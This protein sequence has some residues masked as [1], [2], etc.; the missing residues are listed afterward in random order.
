MATTTRTD[1]DLLRDVRDLFRLTLDDVARTGISRRTWIRIEQGDVHELSPGVRARLAQL[2]AF[3]EIVGQMP[4]TTA[5]DWAIRPLRTMGGKTPRD[6]V[7]TPTGLAYLIA[8]LK[9]RGELVAT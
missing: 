1:A 9:S 6:L 8:R 5:R 2:R 3:M 7:Q 4:Y